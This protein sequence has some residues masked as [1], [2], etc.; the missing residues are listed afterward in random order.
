M[1]VKKKIVDELHKPAR[2]RFERRKF[3]IKGLF[4]YF[5]ADLAD[6]QSYSKENDGYNFILVVIDCFSKFVWVEPQRNKTGQETSRAFESILKR[7]KKAP[8]ILQVD[9]GGEFYN[10][11]F[12]SLMKRYKI[13][14]YSTY[15][16]V[17]AGICERFIR[18]LK[19]RLWKHFA[20]TGS[21][22]YID[23]LQ[24]IIRNYNN[25]KHSTTGFKP[26]D[27]NVKNEQRILRSVYRRTKETRTGK[28]KK[29]DFVRISKF[30]H[31]F[32]KGYTPSW[33][34]EIFEIIEKKNT[35]PPTYVLKDYRGQ[36][37]LGGF[38][39]QELQKTLYPN[40][41][42]V[43]KVIK[44]TKNKQYV[45]WLGF[46]DEHNSWIDKI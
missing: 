40:D 1:D 41:Y 16:T 28:F 24:N 26:V 35:M 33:T 2:K 4:E 17:K 37:I 32:A 20:L 39:E 45:K 30:K 44:E 27:V 5:Q 36:K 38:Y 29:G 23:D 18:T 6:L 7:C 46:N 19:N 13:H 22:N 25:T 43:E 15:S 11:H 42:L 31:V 14:Y 10:S 21:Y 3:E 12:S 9:N 34:T 8:K